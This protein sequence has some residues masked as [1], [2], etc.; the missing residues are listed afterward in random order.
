[1]P[2]LEL[3]EGQPRYLEILKPD[4]DPEDGWRRY[5]VEKFSR[6]GM[7]NLSLVEDPQVSGWLD[8]SKERC[9]WVIPGHLV[10][11]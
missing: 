4:A 6:D 3:T 7:V 1:M 8:L 9:R 2:E 5:F 11:G 10:G